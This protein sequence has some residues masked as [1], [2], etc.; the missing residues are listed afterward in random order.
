MILLYHH[1]VLNCK[2]KQ[3]FDH[4]STKIHV[5]EKTSALKINIYKTT[6]EYNQLHVMRQRCL[7]F[8]YSILLDKLKIR[9]ML[10][11]NFILVNICGIFRNI[12]FLVITNY[13]SNSPIIFFHSYIFIVIFPIRLWTTRVDLQILFMYL[14]EMLCIKRHFI[15]RTE[16]FNTD[17]VESI[18]ALS[19]ILKQFD[20]KCDRVTDLN[21]FSKCFSCTNSSECRHFYYII[22]LWYFS[23]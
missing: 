20:L 10:W 2:Q 13:Y 21:I 18:M 1:Q 22:L 14:Q 23:I 4:S 6:K 16:Y 3:F 5:N 7:L 15:A 11:T 9:K 17:K 12:Y 8:I 19:L